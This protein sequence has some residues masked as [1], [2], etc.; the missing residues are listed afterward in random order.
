MCHF[1]AIATA[2]KSITGLDLINAF[3]PEAITGLDLIGA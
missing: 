3:A 1:S 2:P